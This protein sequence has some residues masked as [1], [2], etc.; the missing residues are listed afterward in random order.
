[1]KLMK[2]FMWLLLWASAG[3]AVGW[4]IGSLTEDIE[5]ARQL[6]R[7]RGGSNAIIHMEE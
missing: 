3:W 2:Q 5:N 1:M 4:G 6:I 7:E